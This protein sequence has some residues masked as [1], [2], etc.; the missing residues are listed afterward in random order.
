MNNLNSVLIEGNL[1]RDPKFTTTPKG[2]PVCTFS[3]ASNR[4]Y[5]SDDGLE[6]EVSYFD[7]ETWG[8]LAETCQKLG[9]KGRSVRVVGRLKQDRWTDSYDKPHSKVIIVAEHVE[10]R[11]EFN[12]EKNQDYSNEHIPEETVPF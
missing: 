2:I 10:F 3:I 6:K 5:R 7:I 11:P 4:F 12:K 9:H 8:K 1:V